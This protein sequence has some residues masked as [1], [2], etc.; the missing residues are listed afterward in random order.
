MSKKLI[1]EV[2]ENLSNSIYDID[3][4]KY[5]PNFNYLKSGY[6]NHTFPEFK[7]INILKILPKP[8]KNSSSKTKEELREI[9]NL[10]S[11][12]SL[13]DIKLVYSVDD[14]PLNIFN[15]IIKK[16]NLVFSNKDFRQMYHETMSPLIDHLKAFY[17]RARPFQLASKLNIKID[18]LLTNTHQTAAYPSGHTVY[19]ALIGEIL[20]D[21]Y[22]DKRG[23]FE[24]LV[25][26]TAKAR[27]LQGVHYPSDNIVSITLMKKLYPYLKKYY[28]KT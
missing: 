6:A 3:S 23:I 13:E 18:V 1:S 21:S 17:N 15:P 12:R 25:Q 20:S 19:A 10:T 27:V 22:P 5:L 11:N 14:D 24:D 7:G 4:I 28:E 16:Y 8:A 2:K 26:K 9:S